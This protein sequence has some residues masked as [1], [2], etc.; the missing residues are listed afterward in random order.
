MGL[1][2]NRLFV[3]AG[4]RK[5]EYEEGVDVEEGVEEEREEVEEEEY[6]YPPWEPVVGGV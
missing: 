1:D 5:G 6:P 2:H 3:I 4:L